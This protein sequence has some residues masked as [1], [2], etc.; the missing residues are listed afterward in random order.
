MSETENQKPHEQM[1]TYLCCIVSFISGSVGLLTGILLASVIGIGPQ[2]VGN[3]GP[4]GPV[5][6]QITSR[7]R[8]TGE[9][10]V[11]QIKNAS[12]RPLRMVVIRMS[13]T[14]QPNPF[15]LTFDSWD[16]GALV[17]I[18]DDDRWRVAPGQKLAVSADGHD[19]VDLV[20]DIKP[21]G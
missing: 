11:I 3:V 19:P 21:D 16:P 4:M 13:A 5:P 9:G 1:P 20:I 14:G 12:T 6:L 7:P 2:R 8:S 10:F 18:G 15:T 17:E